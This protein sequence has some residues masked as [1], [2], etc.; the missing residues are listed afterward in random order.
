MRKKIRVIAATVAVSMLA[1]TGAAAVVTSYNDT[2][3]GY[4]VSVTP[5]VRID[6]AKVS[7]RDE[8]VYIE[9]AYKDLHFMPEARS[10]NAAETMG[11]SPQTVGEDGRLEGH[12]HAYVHPV[13]SAEVR[14]LTF[15]ILSEELSVGEDGTSGVVGGFC[16]QP[17]PKGEYRISAD[18]QTNF[19]DA[20][21]KK[22]PQD[23]PPSDSVIIKV[24]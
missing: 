10:G 21:L 19:H 16:G 18:V 7:K 17:V 24:R 5:Q 2:D 22:H 4:Q 8:P 15:C 9:I 3:R 20:P 1:A 6:V 14:A 12:I 11:R 13:D 23:V